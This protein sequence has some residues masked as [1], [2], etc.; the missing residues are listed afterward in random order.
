M[1]KQISHLQ[2]LRRTQVNIHQCNKEAHTEFFSSHV[3]RSMNAHELVLSTAT[4]IPPCVTV[5]PVLSRS[6]RTTFL[7]ITCPGKPR[8]G[9]STNVIGLGAPSGI[10]WAKEWKRADRDPADR[11]AVGRCHWSVCELRSYMGG[12]LPYEAQGRPATRC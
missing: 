2:P 3:G 4:V 5:F 8:T 7:S 6:P 10:P 12:S 9:I 11:R 1:D